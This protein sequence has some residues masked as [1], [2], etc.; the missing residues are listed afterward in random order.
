MRFIGLTGG[1]FTMG[2][3]DAEPGRW[4][5][6][7]PQHR[8]YISLLRVARHVVTQAQWRAVMGDDPSDPDIGHGD[9]LPV[10]NI[11]WFEALEFLNRLS[12]REGRT[13][14]YT[15]VAEGAWRWDRAADGYRLPTEAEWEFAAR[16]GTTTAYSFGDDPAALE[17]HAW[18]AGN[19]KNR[20][21][22]VGQLR[23][24][25]WDLHDMHGLVWEWTWQPFDN[26][27]DRPTID[28]GDGGPF[29]G[30]RVLRGGSFGD[31][32][33]Y[34]RSA[35]RNWLEPSSRGRSVGFRCIRAS[36]PQP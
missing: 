17:H 22:P 32:P 23:A 31:G 36:R 13:P 35:Y 4:S 7:G 3:P 24:N 27:V 20:L 12:V 16:A 1:E 21:H 10:N 25:P 9:D 26:Y 28:P 11:T 30:D 14:C 29:G 19:S 33:G 18:Y 34:L 15:R 8:V 5:D 2:S 6:E